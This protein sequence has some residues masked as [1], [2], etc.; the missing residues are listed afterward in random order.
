E[1]DPISTFNGVGVERSDFKQADDGLVLILRI[2]ST[3]FTTSDVKGRTYGVLTVQVN[4][5]CKSSTISSSMLGYLRSS[6]SNTSAVHS[7]LTTYHNER[8]VTHN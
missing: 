5:T 6:T 8:V 1:D 3:I 2:S 7:S 4:Q